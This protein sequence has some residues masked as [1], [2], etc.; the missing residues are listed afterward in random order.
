MLKKIFSFL[1]LIIFI[2]ISLSGQ[3][4]KKL[5]FGFNGGWNYSFFAGE[6]IKN[7]YPL[8]GYKICV[9]SLYQFN[10]YFSIIPKVSFNKSGGTVRGNYNNEEV[11]ISQ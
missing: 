7:M 10:D 8:Y 11:N 4:D 3:V 9:F 5:R 6:N 2:S 1:S